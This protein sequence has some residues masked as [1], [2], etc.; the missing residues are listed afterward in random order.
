MDTFNQ[1]TNG[2][3]TLDDID[4]DVPQ[5][6]AATGTHRTI[7]L[8]TSPLP[9][10]GTLANKTEGTDTTIQ[11][12]ELSLR[13]S[14][15]EQKINALRSAI[16]SSEFLARESIMVLCD[17]YYKEAIV[18]GVIDDVALMDFVLRKVIS[19]PESILTFKE[20]MGLIDIKKNRDVVQQY[21]QK[22]RT[23]VQ[24]IV[25]HLVYAKGVAWYKAKIFLAN[26]SIEYGETYSEEDLDASIKKS[27]L[28]FVNSFLPDI[29]NLLSDKNKISG[30]SKDVLEIIYKLRTNLVNGFKS[31]EEVERLVSIFI[32]KYVSKPEAE[33]RKVISKIENALKNEIA[34]GE[35]HYDA[36]ITVQF[37]DKS[38]VMIRALDY[39]IS[40]L[41]N[42]SYISNSMDFFINSTTRGARL[43]VLPY[44]LIENFQPAVSYAI[45]DEINLEL[46]SA[47]NGSVTSIYQT[48]KILEDKRRVPDPRKCKDL[49]PASSAF[50]EST[51]TT[52][53]I[54]LKG[55]VANEFR[56]ILGGERLNN[57]G[58]PKEMI[59]YFFK[60]FELSIFSLNEYIQKKEGVN[61]SGTVIFQLFTIMFL[62]FKNLFHD[63]LVQTDQMNI[64]NIDSYVNDFYRLRDI[65]VDSEALHSFY[66]N[67]LEQR[68][69]NRQLLRTIPRSNEMAD[70][71]VEVFVAGTMCTYM[72][73]H[74]PSATYY[75][76]TIDE[77]MG[78]FL[79]FNPG[80]G[81]WHELAEHSVAHIIM[82]SSIKFTLNEIPNLISTT[83]RLFSKY[84]ALLPYIIVSLREK[85]T[86]M[87]IDFSDLKI[88][89][90]TIQ[91]EDSLVPILEEIKRKF[92]KVED[93][94]GIIELL[95]SSRRFDIKAL[96]EKCFSLQVAEA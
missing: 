20:G 11:T 70:N 41:L 17:I 73:I 91:P 32:K 45:E 15:D 72:R 56:N 29:I 75:A 61:L 1:T 10:T 27:T 2:T 24:T 9:V 76:D 6:V 49:N 84:E 35:T 96:L 34:F 66:S 90:S 16:E 33:F 68:I 82:N 77:V 57:T 62:R 60:I 4:V 54:D 51:F 58:H 47:M 86:L 12:Q 42:L 37:Q 28:Q 18:S 64:I 74:L 93:K 40:R 83:V 43:Q 52:N 22:M 44:E 59:E 8:F 39:Y 31:T 71:H 78:D 89:L 87:L 7:N 80:T 53:V 46:M 5:N 21:M 63:A 38:T 94:Y 13:V 36:L 85:L 23:N 14:I 26:L 25:E 67:Q 92:G 79:K 19:F 69:E 30:L 55:E 95:S 81:D 50:F 65:N 48:K 88:T 3:G